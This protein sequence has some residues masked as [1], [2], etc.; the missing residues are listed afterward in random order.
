MTRV[1]SAMGGRNVGLWHKIKFV[2][3]VKK[4]GKL[5]IYN[6]N[7]GC[8]TVCTNCLKLYLWESGGSAGG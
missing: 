3:M 7:T 4:D 1:Q 8:K 2:F 6:V 5:V